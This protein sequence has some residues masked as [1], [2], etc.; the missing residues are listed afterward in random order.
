MTTTHDE[1][2]EKVLF[3]ASEIDRTRDV[4]DR[5]KMLHQETRAMYPGHDTAI[6]ERLREVQAVEWQL[7]VIAGPRTEPGYHANGGLFS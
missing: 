5:L 1:G 6:D 3:T 2:P 7:G 4:L